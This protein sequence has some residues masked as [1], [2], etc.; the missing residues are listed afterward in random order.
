[1]EIKFVLVYGDKFIK[2]IS[3]QIMIDSQFYIIQ[4]NLIEIRFRI[5]NNI[6]HSNLSNFEKEQYLIFTLDEL[7][8]QLKSSR[9]SPELNGMEYIL[10]PPKHTFTTYTDR[11]II[12][13]F[14][15]NEDIIKHF[16]NNLSI[17]GLTRYS[18]VLHRLVLHDLIDEESDEE[19]D[20]YEPSEEPDED[21]ED[22]DDDDESEQNDDGYT[23]G[24]KACYK[25]KV[26]SECPICY[27]NTSC[28]KFFYCNH[29]Q[30]FDCYLQMKKNICV[31]RCNT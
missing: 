17:N 25:S 7:L 26:Q 9:F 1:M 29:I 16:V 8:P 5:M 13:I 4:D 28:Y 24:R 14:N 11:N 15:N 20:D 31:Y 19:S 27:D 22:D 10:N 2:I 21:D 18:I 6:Y 12:N 30:C 23:L 3:Q